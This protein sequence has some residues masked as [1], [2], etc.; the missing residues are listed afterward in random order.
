[1]SPSNPADTPIVFVVGGTGAQGIPIIEALVKDRR[2]KVRFLTRDPDSARARRLTLLGNVEPVVGTFASEDDLRKGFRGAQYAFINIDGFNSGEKTEIFWAMRAYELALEEGIQFFVYGN[3]DFV[4][5]KSGY[6]PKF[7]TGHYDGKGRV[8]E[9]I[10]HQN[11]SAISAARMGAAVFTTGPYIAMSIASGTPMSPTVEGDVVT[12]RVPLGDGAVCHVDLDDCGYYVRWLFDHQDR[13]NG[14]DLEVAIDLI[15]YD[16]LAKAFEKVTGHAARYIDTDLDMYWTLGPLGDGTPSSGYN[17]ALADPAAM[18]IRQNFTGFWNM[19][20]GSGGNKGVIQRDFK[21]LD[22]IFPERTKSA[23]EWFRKE[24]SKGIAQ[25]LGSL[26][27]RVNNLKPIL[28]IAEDGR[29]G[30]L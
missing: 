15:D 27:D 7:R 26:W 8:A 24:E 4:Y 23:E 29:R 30:K 6:D 14:M 16:T 1:M 17:S 21:L 10:L 11:K 3:L 19:W 22:E 5:K 2:Y 25:G 9:W 18:T 28:K 20:K 12:W 13:A